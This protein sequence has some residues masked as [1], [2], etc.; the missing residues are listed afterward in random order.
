MA[1]KKGPYSFLD[2]I[3]DDGKLIKR[4]TCEE[5]GMIAFLDPSI[6]SHAATIKEIE[7]SMAYE[8]KLETQEDSVRSWYHERAKIKFEREPED[9]K[10]N[11]NDAFLDNRYSPETILFPEEKTALEETAE[12]T[13]QII[14]EAPENLKEFFYARFGDGLSVSEIGRRDGVSEA[15][16]RKYKRR[17]EKLVEDGLFVHYG[18]LPI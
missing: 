2:V 5:T 7:D 13:R 18:T 6:P 1:N 16:R 11:P 8:E 15:A 14:D 3:S 4:M 9:V 12:V 17:L 10:D